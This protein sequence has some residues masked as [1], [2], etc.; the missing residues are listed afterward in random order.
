MKRF[1]A[2]QQQGWGRKQQNCLHPPPQF[3]VKHHPGERVLPPAVMPGGVL[4]PSPLT[5]PHTFLALRD[6]ERPSTAPRRSPLRPTAF[7]GGF[8][9]SVPP[10][11]KNIPR[12][13]AHPKPCTV[14][15]RVPELQP[16]RGAVS[17]PGHPR[18]T[19]DP[20]P[21][22]PLHGHRDQG[23]HLTLPSIVSSAGGP[24]LSGRSSHVPNTQR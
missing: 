6:A 15:C 1:G 5:E 14:P 18:G 9:S 11:P 8:S 4:T 20:H 19:G 23:R 12:S 7:S 3:E 24:A 16:H 10:T 22:P 13:W 17:T 2:H 21:P